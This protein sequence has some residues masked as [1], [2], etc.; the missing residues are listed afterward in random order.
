MKADILRYTFDQEAQL[1]NDIR[2]HYPNALFDTLVDSTGISSKATLLEIGPGTGQATKPLAERGFNIMAIELGG[3]LADVARHELQGYPNVNVITGAFED[4]EL[5]AASFNLVFSATA[6]HWIQP[7]VRYT[8]PYEILKP[9]GHLAIIHTHHVSDE[10]GDRF[11]KAAQPVYDRFFPN[12]TGHIPTLMGSITATKLDEKLFRLVHFERFP[13]VVSYSAGEYA[14]L[15]NTFSPILALPEKERAAF[16]GA[17][18]AVINEQF[19]GHINKH[20]V[21]SLT[22]AKKVIAS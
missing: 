10:Q 15:L 2:P 8:K 7:E 19:D 17:I 1:Y 9:H 22:I 18:E 20:F 11:F 5:Q 21:M 13:T 3:A 6:F 4:I 14:K 12:D 16:L